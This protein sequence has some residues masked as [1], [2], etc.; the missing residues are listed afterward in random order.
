MRK[1][2]TS[3]V[4]GSVVY[5][6][7]WNNEYYVAPKGFTV[8]DIERDK[9]NQVYFTDDKQDAIDTADV[10]RHSRDGVSF[11]KHPREGGVA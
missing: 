7:H 4:T 1:V 10:L 11:D 8:R 2:Y 9:D 6:S 3:P 5:Y